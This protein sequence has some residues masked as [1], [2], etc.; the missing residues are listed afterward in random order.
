MKKENKNVVSA[1]TEI[2]LEKEVFGG[3]NKTPVAKLT[4]FKDGKVQV[5]AAWVFAYFIDKQTTYTH[6]ADTP[7]AVTQIDTYNVD[8]ST[9]VGDITFVYDNDAKKLTLATTTS[10]PLM[11]TICVAFTFTDEELDK[12]PIIEAP[13][14]LKKKSKLGA[15]IKQWFKELIPSKEK[16]SNVKVKVEKVPIWKTFTIF[17][18][19]RLPWIMI[20]ASLLTAIGQA[21]IAMYTI[22]FTASVIDA[23]GS[24]PTKQLTE[25]ALFGAGQALLMVATALLQG[26]L[27]NKIN[28]DVRTKLWTKLMKLRQADLGADGGESYVSRITVDSAYASTYFSQSVNL[29]RA[30]VS[31][32]VYIVTMFQLSRQLAGVT[33]IFVPLTVGLGYLVSWLKYRVTLKRQGFIALSTAYLIERTKD[34]T[35]IKTCNTQQKEIDIGNEYFDRM[36]SNQL[37][38]G[39]IGAIQTLIDNA[40]NILSTVIPYAMGAVLYANGQISLGSIVVFSNMIGSMRDAMMNAITYVTALKEANGAVAKATKILAF[41]EEKLDEGLQAPEGNDDIKFENVTF[42]YVEDKTVLNDISF[43][44]PKNKVTA[45]LGKNGSGKTTSFKLIERLY[46]IDR[47][48]DAEQYADDVPEEQREKTECAVRY[49]NDNIADYSLS[50]W[51]DKITLVQQGGALMTG[52]LRS[53]ICYGRDDVTE[54]E[55]EEVVKLAHVSDFAEDLPLKYDSPVAVDGNN[56]SG[57]QKQCIAIARAMLSKKPI[58]LLDEATCNLDAK[59]EADVMNALENLIKDRTTIIIAHS[60]G[61]VKH[62]NHVIVLNQGKVESTGT[63]ADILKQTDNYLAKMMKRAS[64]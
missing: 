52:T 63:P 6:L 13:T 43:T 57:G 21:I 18:G 51:R 32:I 3:D 24:I 46:E 39:F 23:S 2:V 4:F 47:Y 30:I 22:T 50:S 1:D 55:F 54:E 35:L 45:V 53:N 48:K 36:Y 11:P 10:N 40:F 34:L 7:L 16:D 37:H 9:K 60:L 42:G 44:V 26:F 38:I 20:I 25:Y 28:H 41:P 56:F 5:Q 61:T 19:I 31:T 59:R 27:T 62:A 33:L 58:L 49:G 14:A 15:A 8:A 12:L 64:A 17:K 29:V